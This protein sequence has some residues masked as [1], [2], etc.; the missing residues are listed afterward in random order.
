MAEMSTGNDSQKHDAALKRVP[1]E[2]QYGL[3]LLLGSGS[4]LL[5][6]TKGKVGPLLRNGWVTTS[7]N[8]YSC[9]RITAD[10]LRA[11]AAAVE[12]YGLPEMTKGNATRQVCSECEREWRPSCRC[13]SRLW[14]YD[15][16][17]VDLAAA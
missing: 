2:R 5:S 6:G 7:G 14:R 15:V 10:G 3:L 8:G 9:A 12:K 16:R 11:L 13:G 17:E 1:T 4:V